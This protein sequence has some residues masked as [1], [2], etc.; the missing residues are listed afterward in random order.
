M[1]QAGDERL[2][3][4]RTVRK[5]Y[6]NRSRSSLTLYYCFNS[7]RPTAFSTHATAT[8][9]HRA[10]VD[11]QAGRPCRYS[12]GKADALSC[13]AFRCTSLSLQS[14]A[15]LNVHPAVV[16]VSFI[17][18]H[19]EPKSKRRYGHYRLVGAFVR[20]FYNRFIVVM[21]TDCT[22]SSNCSIAS[23]ISSTPTFG[24]TR[25]SHAGV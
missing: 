21:S 5:S 1:L 19:P 6:H 2:L 3:R 11:F 23:V 7:I 13:P 24:K 14:H 18:L 8:S 9:K 25:A 20:V 15:F 22:S 4:I 17:L 16:Y 10:H 12:L